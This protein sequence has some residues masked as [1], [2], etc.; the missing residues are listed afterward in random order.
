MK[1]HPSPS[2][3]LLSSHYSF[4]AFFPSPQIEL[5]VDAKGSTEVHSNPNS[6]LH[7]E[8]HPSKLFKLPS[9]H[10]SETPNFEFEQT[11]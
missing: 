4:D 10:S 11:S 6:I 1:L 7:I 2:R 5:Q 8:E 3:V 9:S